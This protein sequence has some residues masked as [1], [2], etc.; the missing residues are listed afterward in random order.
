MHTV[1][2]LSIPLCCKTP[3]NDSI[4]NIEP[5]LQCSER[6]RQMYVAT[7]QSHMWNSAASGALWKNR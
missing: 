7:Q 6:S 4:V 2:W 3:A 1:A 5:S